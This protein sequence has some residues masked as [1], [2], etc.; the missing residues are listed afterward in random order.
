MNA[1]EVFNRI[2]RAIVRMMRRHGHKCIVVYVD[3]FIIICESQ[4][5]AWY[6]YWTLRLLLRKLG[7]QVNMKPHKSI[8]PCQV[9]DFLGVELDSVSMQARL[10]QSKLQATL[11]LVRQALSSSSITRRNFDK[12]NGKL[13]WVCKVVYGGR[14]FL[15]RLIDAQWSVSRPHHHIR[16]SST[17]RLDTTVARVSAPF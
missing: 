16:I 6:I 7:F 12:L 9:L 11:S 2:G 10:S 1:C 4:T 17:V 8:P 3:D 13:N 15:R 14:T 5:M